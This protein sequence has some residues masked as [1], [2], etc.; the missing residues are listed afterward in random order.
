MRLLRPI[1]S[2]LAWLWRWSPVL[3]VPAALCFLHWLV[4]FG[5]RVADFRLRYDASPYDFGFATEGGTHART[6]LRTL[7]TE[8]G[9]GGD[10]GDLPTVQLLVPEQ[11]LARLDAH[12]PQSGFR[13]VDGMLV[14]DDGLLDVSVRYRGDYLY[15][16]A[17]PK[18]SW[19]VRLRGR[20]VLDGLHT[21]NLIAPKLT[22]QINDVLAARLAAR[23]GVPTPR[24][25]LVQ[26][27]VNGRPR[28]LHLL[29]EQ[30]G[31]GLLR[32][33]QRPDGEV[34]VGELHVKDEWQ[35]IDQMVFAH[36][37]LWGRAVAAPDHSARAAAALA[38]LC[39]LLGRPADAAAHRELEQVLDVA[40]FGRFVA[41]T[42]L[43]Q[44]V[45]HDETHNWRLYHD[46][47]RDRLQPILWDPNAWPDLVPG[48]PPPPVSLD[49]G[50]SR[51]HGMLL[52]NATFLLARQQALAGFF[53][54]G[55]AAAFLDEVTEL[56]ALAAPAV[57]CDP[58]LRPP[59][60]AAVQ[61]AMRHL[62]QGIAGVF[63]AV[64][65][66]FLRERAP[67]RWQHD[68]ASGVIGLQ[69][70]DRVP[71]TEVRL[72][73]SELPSAGTVGELQVHRSAATETVPLPVALARGGAELRLPVALL[74]QLA[75]APRVVDG[76]V[77]L[78]RE[79]LPTNYGLRIPGVT[80]PPQE[81][82]VV[83]A[84]GSEEVAVAAAPLPAPPLDLLF[85]LPRVPATA[86]VWS[87]EVTVE[88]SARIGG[89]LE[90][91][92][93]TRIRLGP[94]ARVHVT[95]RV[96]ASGTA[97]RAI[98][99][100]RLDP[101]RAWGALVLGPGGRG[102]R[103]S[104]CGFVGGGDAGAG[105]AADRWQPPG[106]LTLH[107]AQDVLL[108]DC[109][110]RDAGERS[111]LLHATASELELR[112]CTLQEA[113][114]GLWVEFGA[115][116]VRDCRFVRCR[117]DALHARSAEVVA[118]GG[119]WSGCG[120]GVVAAGGT[121]LLA[122]ALLEDVGAGVVAADAA[123]VAITHCVLDRCALPLQTVLADWTQGAAGRLAAERCVLRDSGGAARA[124]DGGRMTLRDCFL[125]RMPDAAQVAMEGC[126]ARDQDRATLPAGGHG[127][128]LRRL[129][130]TG[131]AAWRSGDPALRGLGG[132]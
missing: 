3:T 111:A 75:P 27:V 51:L 6:I 131:E 24:M 60:P 58:L 71:V 88:G 106:M 54:S 108:T 61:A 23:L 15:H 101:S 98:T 18:K 132:N 41:A 59:D 130:G 104:H 112:R 90:I 68:A 4:T 57:A 113:G 8:L 74:A 77:V 97:E 129:R 40:A 11:E 33:L 110:F 117:G 1:A 87:G 38:R 39:R 29:V 56:A 128:A 73:Y 99:L 17:H 9:L 42:T 109:E 65:A 52:G 78:T 22:P 14:A 49:L 45:H 89:D 127:L 80:A 48:T 2:I 119:R 102:S 67:V 124:R 21:F 86:T 94:G 105:A 122:T 70:A 44:S 13:S 64:E 30:I 93:G 7:A 47:V 19:R 12:L 83:R 126:D 85:A 118:W 26:V 114:V 123:A 91:A 115:A 96:T 16:W 84:D 82:R 36:P 55:A 120:R 53:G 62:R 107:D 100:Q 32:R 43:M 10:G 5:D 121:L 25:E 79:P 46:P 31:A 72:R 63:G 34:L 125:D 50:V 20:R 28:G 103:L 116:T 35:G 76:S 69:V 81:V 92:P 66:A 95:G 37:G